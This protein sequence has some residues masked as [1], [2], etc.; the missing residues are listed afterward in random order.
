MNCSGISAPLPT[1]RRGSGPAPATK[2][3][4]AATRSVAQRPSRCGPGPILRWR[5]GFVIESLSWFAWHRLAGWDSTLYDD[6]PIRR[7]VIECRPRRAAASSGDYQVTPGSSIQV[8][9]EFRQG[10]VGAG[11]VLAGADVVAGPGWPRGLGVSAR[12]YLPA[13]HGRSPAAVW[14]PAGDAENVWSCF[15]A[16]GVMPP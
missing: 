1:P 11:S 2:P 12:L 10:A 3:T 5:P 9:D 8:S 15:P 7:T 16:W 6:E 14:S 4:A 13:P